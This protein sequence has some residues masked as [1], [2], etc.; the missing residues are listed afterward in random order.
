MDLLDKYMVEVGKHLPRKNRLDLQAEIRST[1]E[2][3]LEDRSQETGRPVDETLIAEVL[4][5][6]GAPAGVAAGYQPVRYLIGP[7]LYPIFEMVVKIVLAVLTVLSLVGFGI[8]A[9][10]SGGAGEAFLASLGKWLLEYLAGLISAFGNIVLVFAI[11]ERVLPTAEFEKEAEAWT[12]ADLDAEPDP[13][14]VKRGELIF[15][16]LFIALALAFINLYPDWIGFFNMKDGAWVFFPVLSEAFFR[17][18]PWIN[19]LGLLEIGLNLY[20]LRQGA[21][22]TVT[23]L[24]HIVFELAGVGLAAVMLVG[25]SLVSLDA[26]LAAGIFGDAYGVMARMFGF[27]PVIVLVI[28]IIVQTIEALQ[29]TWRLL[30]PRGVGKTL[31]HTK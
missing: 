25:P 28:V 2:D 12:P 20:L 18:L 31:P 19:L 22:Q 30:N 23:R 10:R 9:A 17:Y 26:A 24:I 27:I 1:I 4:K 6:Y 3:M 15:E 29:A 8:V 5:E 13:D 16:T 7:R 21:W 11:L 14:Q